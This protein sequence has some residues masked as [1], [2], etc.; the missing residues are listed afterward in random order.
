MLLVFLLADFLPPIRLPTAPERDLK[1][2]DFPERV[3]LAAPVISGFARDP[4]R[5]TPPM[6]IPPFPPKKLLFT[7]WELWR[8]PD[9]WNSRS[10]PENIC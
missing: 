8:K 6:S 5:N 3:F 10:R 7:K 9:F 4:K 1:T 2:D